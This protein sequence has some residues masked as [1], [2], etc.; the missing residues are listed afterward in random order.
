MP[1]K[2]LKPIPR[3]RSDEEAGEF[4]MTHDSVHRLGQSAPGVIPQSPAIDCD[5]FTATPAGFA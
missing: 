4:W 5:D 2:K 1:R 3:F